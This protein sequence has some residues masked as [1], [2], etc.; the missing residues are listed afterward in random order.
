MNTNV[1]DEVKIPIYEAYTLSI[2]EAAEYFGIGQTRLR[3]LI[4]LNP[5]AE[6]LISIGNRTRIKRVKFEQFIDTISVL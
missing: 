4:R 6:Y 1:S 2:E 5:N 3:R